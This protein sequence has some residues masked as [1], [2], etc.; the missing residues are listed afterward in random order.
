[1]VFCYQNCSDLLCEK[2]VQVIEEKLVKFEAEGREF[3]KF[4][5]SL[6]LNNPNFTLTVRTPSDDH[7]F[8]HFLSHF[9]EKKISKGLH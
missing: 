4:F 3:A 2:N 6:K 8:L 9:G 7:I 5:R 1:M